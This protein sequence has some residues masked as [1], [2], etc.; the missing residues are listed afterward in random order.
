MLV[1][2]FGDNIAFKQSHECTKNNSAIVY[3]NVT[4]QILPVIS[5]GICANG[6]RANRISLTG[7]ANQEERPLVLQDHQ[8][9][10]EEKVR[11]NY[12]IF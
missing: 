1:Y 5:K 8:V 2:T 6:G 3:G 7:H 10:M 9:D 11:F 12:M 4:S